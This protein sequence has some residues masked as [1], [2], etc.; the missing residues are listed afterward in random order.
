MP[1]VPRS[2]YEP[3]EDAAQVFARY[4]KTVEEQQDIRPELEE[5]GIREMNA[6][7]SIYD[8]DRLTGLS[9][10]VWRRIGRNA[11]VTRKR[12]PTVR[13]IKPRDEDTPPAG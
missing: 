6:G 13:S 3:P 7:A 8:L 5:L 10:E 9:R 11:G 1:G 12:A 2:S 4:K